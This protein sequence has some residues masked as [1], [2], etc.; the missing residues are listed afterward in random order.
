[1]RAQPENNA[2][3]PARLS[4]SFLGMDDLTTERSFDL[5]PTESLVCLV[6]YNQALADVRSTGTACL[7]CI[8]QCGC[9]R[10]FF[11]I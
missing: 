4:A 10:L 9:V 1:M 8:C 6:V 2:R 5:H 11:P 7:Y 3:L